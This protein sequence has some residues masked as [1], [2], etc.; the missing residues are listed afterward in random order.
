M[1]STTAD[2]NKNVLLENNTLSV[3]DYMSNYVRRLTS[4]DL[5]SFPIIIGLLVI[6]AIFQSQNSVFLT[7]VNFVNLIRQ[8]AG[9]TIMAYGVVFVLLLGEIDLSIGY[10]SGIGGVLVAMLLRDPDWTWYTAIPVALLAT[11]GIGLA[12]GII[13]TYFR[14]PSFIVTLSGLLAWNGVVLRLMEGAGT[15]IIQDKVVTGI[16]GAYMP[17]ISQTEAISIGEISLGKLTLSWGLILLVLFAL[18]YAAMQFLQRNSRRREGL[19]TRP[20]PVIMFQVVGLLVIAFIVSHVVDQD[21]GLPIAG[22]I[23]LI[24]LVIL[25]FVA[26][27]TQFGRFVYAVGGNQEAAR[28]AGINV[29]RIRIMVFVMS[30]TLAGFGGIILAS[31][32]RSVATN[33]GGGD[34]LLNAIAAAV[35]GGTSLFGGHGRV[36]SAVLGA[37][38]ITS[39]ANGM[40]LLNLSS[41]DKFIITGIVL[42]VAVIVDSISRRRQQQS[43]IA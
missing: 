33:T 14:V 34:I 31:R 32:L 40:G 20:T 12:Q 36:S 21:R 8:M 22:V 29:T 26:T 35:I 7:P 38:V 3:S 25:S 27:G 1:S 10:V 42:L 39:V 4:G 16:A 11:A 6:A 18:G 24:L 17:I 15:V 37:L 30:S 28:R 2:E 43:G 41:G 13:I 19:S 5:G 9:I 23:M